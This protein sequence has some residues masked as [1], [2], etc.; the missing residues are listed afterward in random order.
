MHNAH[1]CV[2]GESDVIFGHHVTDD[3]NRL[4][5]YLHVL[6]GPEDSVTAKAFHDQIRVG[7]IQSKLCGLTGFHSQEGGASRP[8]SSS[9]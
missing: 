1:K 9:V 7:E 2:D 8:S 3:I 5:E 6:G 4:L